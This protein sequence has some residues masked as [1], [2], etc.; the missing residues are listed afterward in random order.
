MVTEN[1]AKGYGL[2]MA[3]KA[4]LNADIRWHQVV[5]ELEKKIEEVLRNIQAIIYRDG[6]WAN[7]NDKVDEILL[8]ID[9][10]RDP[11]L[12]GVSNE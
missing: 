11:Q 9:T 6:H 1:Q 4:T 7:H 10:I 12:K 2:G 8:Y 5:D 3:E